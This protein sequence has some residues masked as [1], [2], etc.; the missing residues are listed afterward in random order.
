MSADRT[1]DWAALTAEQRAR[2]TTVLDH[3]IGA[4][5]AHGCRI[6]IDGADGAAD[7]LGDGLRTGLERQG[8]STTRTPDGLVVDEPVESAW[9]MRVWVRGDEPGTSADEPDVVV[10]LVDP[11]W[12]VLRHADPG[13]IA[14][15]LWHRAESRAFFAARA[16]TWDSKFG[17]DLPAYA[18]AVVEA[19]IAVG[20]VAVD[21][22]CGTGRALPALRDAVGPGG[23]VIGVDHTPQMLAAAGDHARA[24]D[25]VLLLADAGNLPLAGRSVDAV[26]AAGLINHLPDPDAGLAELARVTRRGGR[27][28][29]FHPSGR[30]ALAARHGRA[31]RPDEP[32]A[33]H[34]LRASTARTGWQLTTYQDPPHRFLA[35]AVRR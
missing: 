5:P 29:L 26:F 9:R 15:D 34:V 18:A 14:A 30:A 32:L 1:L 11:H 23:T 35:V 22:G 6:L 7:L 27:L 20:G 31:L 2:W 3:L 4:L 25:A 10:D 13:L 16:T 8:R 33:E 12:P 17:A 28:V 21:V 19:S 24:G